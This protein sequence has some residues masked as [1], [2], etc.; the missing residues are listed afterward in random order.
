MDLLLLA[1]VLWRKKWI[2]ILIPILAGAA[3]YVFTMDEIDYY[4]SKAQ[5]ATGFT[6]NDQVQLTDEKFNI[7]DA[8]VKFSNLLNQMTSA[9]PAN[10]VAFRLLKHDLENPD[11]FRRNSDRQE[12]SECETRSV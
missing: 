4:R 10:M 12:V 11:P 7:R 8:D 1:K 6:M 9:I 3:A 5:I 2:L